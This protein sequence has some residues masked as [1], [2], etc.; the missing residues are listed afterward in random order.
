MKLYLYPLLLLTSSFSFSQE[1]DTI[2]E[3]NYDEELKLLKNR[4][5][6][7]EA[8]SKEKINQEKNKSSLIDR[9]KLSFDAIMR[10]GEM[11]WNQN[12]MDIKTGER[13][14]PTTR[15]WSRALFY[16]NL[17]TNITEQ[18]SF[19]SSIMT[20]P[21]F[22]FGGESDSKLSIL[23]NELWVEYKPAK[24]QTIRFGR[25]TG[26]R[27]WDNYI[28]EQF[29]WINHDGISYVSNYKFN[30][31]LLNIKSALF[32]EKYVDNAS[33]KKQGKMY[34]ISAN[35]G[36]DDEIKSWRLSSG[37]LMAEKLPNVYYSDVANF[38]YPGDLA[39][40]Y[41]IWTSH[42]DIKL[43]QLSNLNFNVNVFYNFKN[44]KTNPPSNLI[45]DKSGNNYFS[46]GN[47]FNPSEAP[48]F[49]KQ[50]FGIYG[51]IGIDFSLFKKEFKTSLAY[52]YMEKY[53]A[54]DYYAQYDL[55][56]WNSTNIQGPEFMILCQLNKW[57]RLR[58]RNFFMQEIKGLNGIDPSYKRSGNRTR[59]DLLINF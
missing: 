10:L 29:D 17:D 2:P 26:S 54:L 14:K 15:F 35:F 28:G 22:A 20:H 49:T 9:S 7:L 53:A 44:Y 57:M 13:I 45:T 18:F 16:L 36:K 58:S 4:I 34:G 11:D 21:Y 31:Y 25:Q 43:K 6:Q 27:I 38:F 3:K 12:N 30:N 56:R 39:P 1:L 40:D 51:N 48:D 47:V 33:F 5:N 46:E 32:I 8:L 41:S 50:N 37:L 42:L 19:R 52:L 24:N 55:A 59:L 23:L